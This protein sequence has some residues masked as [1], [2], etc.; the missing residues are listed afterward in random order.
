[1]GHMNVMWYVGKFDEA[2][3]N[4]FAGLGITSEYMR[5]SERGM[6]AVRQE[7]EYLSEVRSG[8]V[9]SVSSALLEARP[10]VLRFRHE[11]HRPNGQLSATTILTA[12]HIDTVARK[13][14]EMPDVIQAGARELLS[15][16]SR[17]TGS[18]WLRVGPDDAEGGGAMRAGG[19]QAGGL[20]ADGLRAG[21]LR[22][23]GRRVE[24]LGGYPAERAR[25][26]ADHGFG[27]VRSERPYVHPVR[28]RQRAAHH[29]RRLT[30]QAERIW[31]RPVR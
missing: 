6:A 16:G 26:S 29:G 8:D 2:T 4:F 30:R 18:A 9:V 19:L 23:G 22:A 10:K 7:L 13:S 11:M 5:E 14:V 20:R 31:Q 15:R 1:M 3:W 21:G 12:V 27:V 17:D 28:R 24:A 25:R